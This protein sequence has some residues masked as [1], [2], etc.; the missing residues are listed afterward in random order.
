MG[1]YLPRNLVSSDELDLRHGRSVG[2]SAALG[3]QTRSVAASDETSSMM[4]S[5]AAKAAINDA[6]WDRCDVDA[7]ICACGVGEQAIPGTA[8]LVQRNL[9]LGRSG[10]P[11]IDVNATCLSFLVGLDHALMGLLLGRWQRVVIASAD[12][13]SAALNHDDVRSSAIFGDGAA[14]V[15]I[16]VGGRSVLL[17][18]S[19]ATYGDHADLC[20]LEA[21]GTKLRP[22]DDM[23]A[24]LGGSRFHMAGPRLFKATAKLLPPFLSRLFT[25]AGLSMH[26]C[27]TVIPH[28]A[29]SHALR[30]LE[31]VFQ[32]GP[33]P[34][35]MNIFAQSGNQIAASLPHAL[36]EAKRR[37]WL[38]EG[39]TS[40]LIGSSAGL[41]LGGALIRW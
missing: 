27:D 22:H 28:Q 11:A 24:F 31:G 13:A 34:R 35:I 40:L 16:E 9:G 1:T 37:D 30:H 12:I 25:D 2:T 19:I 4:A 39:S 23:E 38:A 3:I 8:P 20:G 21:G 15:A 7:L 17:A 29:S 41:S 36:A 5:E 10:I 18:S 26:A 14:A 32:G 6:G 33:V